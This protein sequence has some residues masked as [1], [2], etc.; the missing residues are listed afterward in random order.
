MPNQVD[1]TGLQVKTVTEIVA[2]LTTSLKEIYGDDINVDPNSPDGQLLNILAQA[3]VDNL[4]MLSLVN[5]SF[6]PDQASGV[7][8]DQRV[9]INGIQRTAGTYT[10]QPVSITVDRAMTLVGLD[11]AI[12]PTGDEFV[13]ADDAG[14]E[15][16]LAA[17]QTI[18]GAGTASYNFRAKDI[19]SVLTSPNTITNQITITLGV[20]A[21][22]NPLTATTTGVEEETDAQLKIRRQMSFFKQATSN[23]DAIEAELLATTGVTDA[24]VVEDDDA[25]TIWCIVEGGTAEDI[26]QV[27]YAKR[28]AGCGMVG[29]EEVVVDRPNGQSITIKYDEPVEEDLY[30]TATLTPKKAGISFDF[31]AI[32][33]ELVA[34]LKYTLNQ[35]ASINEVLAALMQIEPEA[36]FSS[37][38]VS[39]TDSAYADYVAT[40]DEQHKLVLTTAHISL[41]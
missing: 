4:E 7:I 19:G 5:A 18:S 33:E 10:V 9:A 34:A 31:A 1:S 25:H 24:L 38:G 23:A 22:N 13:V 14:N 41:T 39:L 20:T 40:T 12:E 8:L 35:P 17:T 32:K 27:I 2:D 16:I 15:F 36:Y 30:I 11:G 26:A 29:A 6:D 21:V 3:I 28:G 37:V